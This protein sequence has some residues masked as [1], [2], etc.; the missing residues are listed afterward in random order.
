MIYVVG[1]T[2]LDKIIHVETFP[3]KN[4]A[5]PIKQYEVVY[6]GGAANSAFVYAKLGEKVSL[7]TL[8]G[9]DFPDS[10]Y[11]KHLK[12]AG[13]DLQFAKVVNDK[14]V[15]AFIVN[16]EENHQIMFFYWGASSKFPEYVVPNL[17][18]EGN[19]VIHMV[20]ANANFNS[21][22]AEKYS[23]DFLIVF[24]VG[25]DINSYTKEDLQNMFKN[26]NIL[27][28]N[29][30]EAEQ[31][32]KLLGIENLKK[33]FE[34]FPSIEIVAETR[35]PD[36]S[37]ILTKDENIHVPAIKPEKIVDTTGA[38]DSY[39]SAFIHY[40]LKKKSLKECAQ[41]ATDIATKV[42]QKRGAQVL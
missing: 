1:H 29:E 2:A 24:D 35:G 3:E 32:K 18:K 21:R 23:K 20:T 31:T 33:L 38:G 13:I 6:G 17:S 36:G 16:N 15:T 19:D 7:V 27:F 30:N 25:Q 4:Q 40:Y 34:M 9:K 42:I 28:V 39:K 8:V 26:V 37:F 10:D 12:S 11:E 5:R 41:F 22:I 14:T